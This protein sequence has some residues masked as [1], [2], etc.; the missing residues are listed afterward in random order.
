MAASNAFLDL[1]YTDDQEHIRQTREN[2]LEYCGQDT[3]GMVKI[4]EVLEKTILHNNMKIKEYKFKE[5]TNTI[6]DIRIKQFITSSLEW[7]KK[8][9]E[10]YYDSLQTCTKYSDDGLFTYNERTYLGFFLSG[11]IRNDK[12]GNFS[13]IQEFGVYNKNKSKGR[14]DLLILDKKEDIYYLIEAKFW[15]GTVTKDEKW[16]NKKTSKYLTGI[17]N[18]QAKKYFKAEK[19]DFYN[20]C[21]EVHLIAIEFDSLIRKKSESLEKYCSESYIDTEKDPIPTDFFYNFFYSEEV[22]K[23]NGLAV[24]GMIRKAR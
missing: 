20:K 10:L 9:M 1:F 14:A 6:K 23:T 4:L 15:R 18:H 2:L 13:A 24:Y 12:G 11:I 17:I 16:N 3:W 8:E 7:M 5:K 21:K 22:S 19:M